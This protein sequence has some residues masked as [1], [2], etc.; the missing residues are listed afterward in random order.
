MLLHP[1]Q[2]TDSLP[3]TLCRVDDRASVTE[4]SIIRESFQSAA[5][6][7]LRQSTLCDR[8]FRMGDRELVAES[9]IVSK[10][11]QCTASPLPRRPTLYHRLSAIDAAEFFAGLWS[12]YPTT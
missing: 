1:A 2:Q 6:S 9:K 4:S 10:S 7:L 12:Q 5:A 3:L 11:F 8:L